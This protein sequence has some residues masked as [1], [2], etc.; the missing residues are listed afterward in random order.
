[1]SWTG[2]CYLKAEDMRKAGRWFELASRAASEAGD[3]SEGEREDRVM[4]ELEQAMECYRTEDDIEGIGRL[5]S[6]R[7]SLMRRPAP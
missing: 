3:L 1:M 5:A 7:D 4:K 2:E 6:L